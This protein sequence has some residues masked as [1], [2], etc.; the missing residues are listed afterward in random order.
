MRKFLIC[1]EWLN[2]IRNGEEKCSMWIELSN[3]AA[4]ESFFGLKEYQRFFP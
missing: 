1:T 2:E 3:S 4:V